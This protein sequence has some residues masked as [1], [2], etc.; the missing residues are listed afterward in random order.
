LEHAKQH[1]GQNPTRFTSLHNQL[2][3]SAVAQG[4]TLINDPSLV[5]KC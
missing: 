4:R 3:A 2:A 5:V 1:I